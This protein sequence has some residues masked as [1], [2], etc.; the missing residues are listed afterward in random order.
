MSV[1]VPHP[2]LHISRPQFFINKLLSESGSKLDLVLP[3][4]TE[5]KNEFL[6]CTSTVTPM[7]VTKYINYMPKD[8]K[9]LKLKLKI[10]ENCIFETFF[11]SKI[12]MPNATPTPTQIVSQKIGAVIIPKPNF[13]SET[14]DMSNPS[15]KGE[16][17]NFQT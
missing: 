2:V 3:N 7:N 14:S 12:Y 1:P 10:S 6:L 8:Q 13:F 9:K 4:Y 16:K 17:N 11:R 15:Q 5:S